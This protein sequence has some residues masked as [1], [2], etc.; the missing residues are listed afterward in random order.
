MKQARLAA[1]IVLS[2]TGGSRCDLCLQQPAF[3]L[4]ACITD[5]RVRSTLNA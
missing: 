2:R 1:V 4:G 3:Y 5:E